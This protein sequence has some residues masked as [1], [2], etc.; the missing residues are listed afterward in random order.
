MVVPTVNTR[1]LSG[2]WAAAGSAVRSESASIQ[3][4]RA[5]GLG[6]PRQFRTGLFGF[7]LAFVIRVSGFLV[8]N[9]VGNPAG[10][11]DTGDGDP[12]TSR[13]ADRKSTRLNSSH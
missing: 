5:E 11:H 12:G 1:L 9:V 6:A 13:D 10:V 3:R 2:V 4:P 7:A 8:V